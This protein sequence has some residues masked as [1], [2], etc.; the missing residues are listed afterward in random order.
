MGQR[1]EVPLRL[2]LHAVDASDLLPLEEL[3]VK[4]SDAVLEAA[5]L[6]VLLQGRQLHLL[7]S[8]KW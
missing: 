4:V 8:M 6:G 7:Q 2:L 5:R 3:H 1:E